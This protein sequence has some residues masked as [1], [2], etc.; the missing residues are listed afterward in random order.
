MVPN[1]LYI[2]ENEIKHTEELATLS[3]DVETVTKE[4]YPN[5][6]TNRTANS[7]LD[8]PAEVNK[9]K[10][11]TSSFFGKLFFS[12][13]AL[14]RGWRH[15]KEYRVALA[16]LALAFLYFTVL[17]FD[18]ITIGKIDMYYVKDTGGIMV[19]NTTL[20]NI[21]VYFVVVTFI[22]GYPENNI[23]PSKVADKL[24]LIT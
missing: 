2:I 22:V 24:L 17:G 16:G 6:G 18:N 15:Y 7:S 23:D 3:K 10:T 11:D 4:Q 12:F 21:S 5:S 14:Y 1:V 8:K 9:S 19:F 20:N 13:I